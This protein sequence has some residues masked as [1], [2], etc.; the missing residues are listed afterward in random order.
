[1]G[2]CSSRSSAVETTRIAATAEFSKP[3]ILLRWQCQGAV[4]SEEA[5]RALKQL[6]NGQIKFLNDQ[7]KEIRSC[8]LIR[9]QR[10]LTDLKVRDSLTAAQQEQLHYSL[11]AYSV[12]L[13]GLN[14]EEQKAAIAF[15]QRSQKPFQLN[16]QALR[17][18]VDMEEQLYTAGSIRRV[19]TASRLPNA[20]PGSN[21]SVRV[22]CAESLAKLPFSNEAHA[23]QVFAHLAKLDALKSLNFPSFN[24]TEEE[25]LGEAIDKLSAEKL[26]ALRKRTSEHQ[27]EVTNTKLFSHHT[28]FHAL[29]MYKRFLQCLQDFLGIDESTASGRIFRE[30]IGFMAK[31]HDF[32]QEKKT[33]AS[34]EISTVEEAT[35][36]TILTWI[37]EKV[38]PAVKV[39]Q[40]PQFMKV[41]EF[42]ARQLIQFGT[43]VVWRADH[44]T[45]LFDLVLRAQKVLPRSSFPATKF[46]QDMQVATVFLGIC[47]KTP[48]ALK[49]IVTKQCEPATNVITQVSP[50]L[51]GERLLL[52]DEFSG[53]PDTEKQFHCMALAQNMMM[54]IELAPAEFK[55]E[56]IYLT[57]CIE[58]CRTA[59]GFD[60]DKLDL[61]LSRNNSRG[62]KA[63]ALIFMND[64]SVSKE[65]NFCILLA[66][67][68]SKVKAQ[69]KELLSPERFALVARQLNEEAPLDHAA[70][71]KELFARYRAADL[72]KRKQIARDIIFTSAFQAGRKYYLCTQNS[73]ADTETTEGGDEQY[74][75]AAVIT[76]PPSVLNK[77]THTLSARSSASPRFFPSDR[78]LPSPRPT[79]REARRASVLMSG[80]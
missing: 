45:D 5:K 60:E 19:A 40:Q 6:S 3:E 23:N 4:L 30:M 63:F 18:L 34:G 1:M 53:M 80:Q 57:Q 76:P 67:Y 26:V 28:Q 66:G 58:H 73:L 38:L 74:F 72:M 64:K 17:Y 39:A 65:L 62:Y 12:Y 2:Q 59:R 42:V 54:Q 71:L 8:L 29:E 69:L 7:T 33:L 50:L 32:E 27:Q 25:A 68:L 9:F 13:A 51:E 52:A 21:P 37:K 16:K 20:V 56:A 47:D 77:Q 31:F 11:V 75:A 35:V 49:N 10:E 44:L 36:E 22:T 43:T 55:S 79:A 41:C 24:A 61:M 70:W 14:Q 78:S 46:Y 15:C 48:W